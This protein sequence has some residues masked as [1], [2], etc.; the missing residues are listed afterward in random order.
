MLAG[1]DRSI[2]FSSRVFFSA[3]I[4]CTSFAVSALSKNLTEYKN[5]VN[6][7]RDLTFQLLYP[8]DEV[9]VSAARYENFEKKTLAEIRKT[10]PPTDKVEWQN[11]SIQTDNRWLSEKL[12]QYES[13]PKDSDKREDIL[14]EISERLDAIRKKVAEI[15]QPPI[16]QRTKDEDKRKLA[17]I[18][19]REE[20]RKPD[21]QEKS[22][23][24]RIYEAVTGWLSEVMPVPDVKS[25]SM[26]G[27]EQIGR[28]IVYGF[29]A[30]IAVGIGFAIYKF[31][32][33]FLLKYRTRVKK[34]K[35]DRVVLGERVAA[36]QKASDLLME[37]ERLA[38][39]GNLR[40]AI[41]KGYIALLCEL[42]DRKIIGLSQHKTNRDYLRDV[43]SRADLYKNMNGLTLNFERHW[44]GFDT[45]QDRD[46]EEFKT[47]YRKALG[48]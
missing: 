7:A 31:A 1:K 23:F 40:D 16:S 18:M 45:A 41:R 43:R 4:V 33:Q 11:S 44:Y 12:D 28:L 38:L 14:T 29:L 22:L 46:W 27:F 2:Y 32:P 21:V 48:N 47:G 13:E 17:E 35:S 3:I 30:L 42:S 10:L 36:D 26:P 34:D 6:Y 20:Y 19:N 39:E 37:A 25:G 9:T 24:M 8:E 15:E 5:D